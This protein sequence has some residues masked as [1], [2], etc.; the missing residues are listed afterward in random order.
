MSDW[1]KQAKGIM[2]HDHNEFQHE[3]DSAGNDTIVIVDF[4]MPH[5]GY[6]VQFM[7]T[8]NKIVDEFKAEYGDK[9]KFVK[10]D[11]IADGVTSDRYG[12]ESFPSFIYLEPGTH[13]KTWKQWEPS[14]RTFAG[15]KKWINGF[16]KKYLTPLHQNDGPADAAK[17]LHDN[18][19]LA[20]P[21]PIAPDHYNAQ[22]FE[23]QAEENKL[24]S[25]AI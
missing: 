10:V 12:V 15:M 4:F 20:Q 8:W 5:C 9:I 7:P 23:K 16:A 25:E 24:M 1:W 21:L 13:G 17:N 22:L 14:H 6:C 11:G 3:V 2:T 19:H 18:Q